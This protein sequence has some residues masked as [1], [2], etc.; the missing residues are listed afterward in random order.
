MQKFLSLS[1]LSMLFLGWA[2]TQKETGTTVLVTEEVLFTS[3]EQVR[4]LGRLISDQAID[5]SDHGFY[6]SADPSFSSPVIISLGPKNVPGRFIGQTSGLL[7]G[8]AYFAKSFINLGGEVQFGNV[9]QLAT[10]NP[11]AESFSPAFG[12]AGQEM[13]ILGKNFTK[14]TK[15]FFGDQPATII[16]IQ[17]ESRLRVRIPLPKTSAVVPVSVQV[18]NKTLI[19]PEN[20]EYQVGKYTK[21]GNF[22]DPVLLY[23]NVFFQNASGFYIGL[24]SESG[25]R[26]YTKFQRYNP[27]TS[28]WEQVAFPRTAR[29]FGFAT[30]NYLGGGARELGREPYLLTRTFW[31][32]NENGFQQLPDL[33]FESRESIG[34]EISGKLYVAGG[35]EGD[36]SLIRRFDPASNSWTTLPRAPFAITSKLASFTFQNRQFFVNSDKV[37]WAFDPATASWVNFDIYPDTLGDGYGMAQV[38]G[39]KVYI[40]L[41]RKNQTIWELDL[42]TKNWKRKNPIP[43]IPQ[44]ITVGHFEHGGQLYILRSTEITIASNSPMEF[45]RFDPNGI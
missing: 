6:L 28:S 12:S 17:F 42:I 2:C 21:L 38:I 25:I 35:K 3:G 23:D 37:I 40:G 31:K 19:F 13:V 22:P 36:P 39:N 10:Q 16:D 4:L 44:S 41:Y 29:V 15:V 9:L 24:G 30:Q 8:K 18:Q 20:F 33:P 34:F 27:S 26:F 5:A 45:Y 43:G 1:I 7:I 14:D 32:I 11:E